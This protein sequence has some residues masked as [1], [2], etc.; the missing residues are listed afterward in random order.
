MKQQTSSVITG[1]I[2]ISAATLEP[3]VS[4]A[5]AAIFHAP[6]PDSVS[7]LVTGAL[8][9]AVHAGINALRARGAANG[10]FAATATMINASNVVSPAV[11]VPAGAQQ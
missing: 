2:T 1:G 4:W 3:A 7:A 10:Q 5:L 8:A 6:V 9:A 11:T